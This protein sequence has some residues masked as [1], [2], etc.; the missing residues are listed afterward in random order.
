M[1]SENDWWTY[2]SHYG[3]KGQKWGVRNGPPYPL[4]RDYL[5]QQAI[6]NGEVSAKMNPEKQSRHIKSNKEYVK[7]RSYLYG[8]LSEAEK[9]IDELSLIGRA[10]INRK[11]GQW[12]KTELVKADHNIGVSVDPQTGI[13]TPTRTAKIHYSNTGTHIVPTK[14]GK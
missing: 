2:L 13:E 3:V 10:L 12:R 4:K 5:I 11:T 6:D 8:D 9:L 1:Y 7:G 14:G